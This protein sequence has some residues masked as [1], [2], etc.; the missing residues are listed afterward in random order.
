MICRLFRS[1]RLRS[2]SRTYVGIEARL[3]RAFHHLGMRRQRSPNPHELSLEAIV[4]LCEAD[5]SD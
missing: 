2:K 5:A 4:R 1:S 3:S